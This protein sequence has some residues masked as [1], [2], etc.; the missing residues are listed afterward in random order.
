[1]FNCMCVYVRVSIMVTVHVCV[2]VSLY[3]CY[4]FVRD[5]FVSHFLLYAVGR[6]RL[7]IENVGKALRTRKKRY[8]L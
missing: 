1:M 3:M 6:G 8:V 2:T 5:L 7:K 4:I